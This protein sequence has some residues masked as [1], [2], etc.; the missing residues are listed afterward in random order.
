LSVL[1][2]ACLTMLSTAFLAQGPLAAY[3]AHGL[4]QLH[5]PTIDYGTPTLTQLHAGVA[6]VRECV[7]RREAVYVHCKAGQART[8]RHTQTE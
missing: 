4:R 3:D 8:H 6:Y 5:L 2:S 7:R 1:F